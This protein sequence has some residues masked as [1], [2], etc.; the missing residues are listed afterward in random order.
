MLARWYSLF[1]GFLFIV[2]GIAG[3][4]VSSR[5]TVGRGGLVATSI[6][7]L[8]IALVSLGVGFGVS[9]PL[10]VRWYSLI[11]GAILFVW[12]II[13]M[14]ASHAATFG[15]MASL[16]SVGLFMVLLGAIGLAAGLVPAVWLREQLAAP[17]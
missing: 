5:I 4:I 2:L 14:I 13:Q 15:M 1:L 7:W 9:N 10:T 8:I 6:I 3:L 16:A 17:A 11:V 12:G